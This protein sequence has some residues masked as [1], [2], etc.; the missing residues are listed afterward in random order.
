MQQNANTSVHETENVT[1]VSDTVWLSA[2]GEKYHRINHC[3][4]MNPDK[5]REVPL[6][7]AIEKGYKKC[8]KC[9]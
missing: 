2:T 9:F 3:G 8:D 6:E 7:N 5:A 1:P 4:R